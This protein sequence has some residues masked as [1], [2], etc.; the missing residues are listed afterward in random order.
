MDGPLAHGD[1]GMGR[2][3]E[4]GWRSPTSVAS[5][6]GGSSTADRRELGGPRVLVTAGP[7]H[8]PIDPVRFLGNRSSGKMGVALAAEACLA[9]RG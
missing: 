3:S 8:E 9:A 2:M 7:T 5:V 1:E 4:P 6:A